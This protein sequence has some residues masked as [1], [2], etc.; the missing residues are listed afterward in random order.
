MLP[1]GRE[2]DVVRPDRVRR[3]GGMLSILAEH[4]LGR[5]SSGWCANI[6][7]TR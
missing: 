3:E 1:V 4:E 6:A 5:T 7:G 2:G